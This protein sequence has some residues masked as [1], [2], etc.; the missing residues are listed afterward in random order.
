MR[1]EQ[2]LWGSTV[3]KKITMA[4]SGTILILFVLLHMLGNLKVYQGPEAFNAY[5]EGL[6]TFGKPFFGESQVLWILRIGLIVALILH[7]V[8]AY[9]L[10]V[11]AN[12]A[13]QVGYKQWD[14]GLVFSYASRTMRWGGASILLFVTYPLLHVTFASAH[15]H[16]RRGDLCQ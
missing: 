9:Q 4:V 1:R 3:G 7:L 12:R 10:T 6:R 16:R 15:T 2:S 5:A 8:A 11:R 13:R 14:G